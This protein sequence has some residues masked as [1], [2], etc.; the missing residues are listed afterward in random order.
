MAAQDY[1][2][3]QRGRAEEALARF[4]PPAG[5]RPAE[6]NE[7]IRYAVMTGGK[8]LRPVLA[9]TASEAVAGEE[10]DPEAALQAAA[11]IEYLHTYTLIHDDLPSMDNDL[12]RRGQPTVHAKFGEALAILAGDALQAYA[13]DVISRTT[14][15]PAARTARLVQV[16]AGAAGPAGVVAGQVEDVAKGPLDEDRLAYVHLHKCA[17]LFRAAVTLGAI[18][19]GGNEDEIHSLSDFGQSLGIAF[20]IID[21]I[22]DEG[23]KP[24]EGETT[25][26]KL[27][28]GREARAKARYFTTEAVAALSGIPG[29][30]A[31]AALAHL[32]EQML[33]RVI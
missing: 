19:G 21:D 4:L 1:L 32:A 31:T 15:L 24:G 8:R 18:A 30:P 27:W 25:C 33:V 23:T 29:N 12:L 3:M 9:L 16:L 11:A 26:L 7:P 17:D 28:T 2:D 10:G 22:L 14:N 6:L 20:Q 5:T 13:F